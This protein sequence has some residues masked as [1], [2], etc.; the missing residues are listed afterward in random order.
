LKIGP[1]YFRGIIMASSQTLEKR[2]PRDWRIDCLRK[3]IDIAYCSDLNR[4][5]DTLKPYLALNKI[6]V[7]YTKELREGNMGIF[8]GVK[9]SDYYK[10]RESEAGKKWYSSHDKKKDEKLPGGE[11][12]KELTV[13]AS[14]ILNKIIKKEKGKNVLIMTH[15]K[16]KKIML[17]YLL[18]RDHAKYSKKYDGS[19]T[20]LS[21]IKIMDD[22]NHK[23]RLIN[24]V[25]HLS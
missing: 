3:K 1:R 22:G 5:R 18:K 16:L 24:S 13:R 14:R 23:A 12:I 8:T 2:S 4:A 25:K 17:A 7:F 9:R 6:K 10:W 15:G 20:A 21:V 11:G 19:N